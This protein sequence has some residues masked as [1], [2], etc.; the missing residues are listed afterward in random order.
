MTPPPAVLIAGGG[1]GGHIYP[2]VAIAEALARERPELAVRFA[3]S[4]RPVDARVFESLAHA[5]PWEPLAAAPPGLKPKALW[6][7]VRRWGPSVRRTRELIRGDE[8]FGRA[9]AVVLT[10]GYIGPPVSQAARVERTPTVLV[11]LDATPGRAARWISRRASVSLIASPAMAAPAGFVALP[12]IVRDAA[13]PPADAATCRARLGL[14]PDRPTLLITGGS[15]GARTLNE[16]VLAWVERD[17]HAALTDTDR[18]QVLHQVGTDETTLR[19]ANEVYASAGV[20]ARVAPFIDDMG[21]AWGAAT[22][23]VG[24]A[25]SSTVSEAWASA[26]PMIFLPYPFHADEHQRRN[27]RILVE[28]GAARVVGDTPDEPDATRAG[29][30]DTLAAWLSDA[31]VRR[32]AAAAYEELPTTDGARQVAERVLTLLAPA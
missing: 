1:T 16:A 6:R 26:T 24:R 19:R 21:A 9:Q 8:Q 13:R 3:C 14:D 28:T 10:G 2:G 5:W 22:L 20:D 11:A 32:R 15:Q 29:L 12:P 7:F 27:T 18:W 30:T 25:G 23:G 4:E 31:D 17:G